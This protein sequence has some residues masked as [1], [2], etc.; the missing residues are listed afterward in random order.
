[1]YQL[2]GLSRGCRGT[3]WE[4]GANP[5][6]MG[7]DTACH[8]VL[9]DPLASRRHCRLLVEDG[10][11]HL[12]DLG[13]RNAALVNGVPSGEGE[14]QA[15]DEL[16]IGR[17]RFLLTK[18]APSPVVVASDAPQETLTL[19]EGM[20][21]TL[22]VT[23]ACPSSDL[24]PSTVQD[25]ALLHD[26]AR[27]LGAAQSMTEVV[28]ILHAL[29]GERLK[30][31]ACAFALVNAEEDLVFLGGEGEQ[32][33]PDEPLMTAI[34]T[35]LESSQGVLVP[36]RGRTGAAR[37]LR[38]CL[39][40]PATLGGHALAILAAET[41]IPHGAFDE[42]DLRFIM[43]LAQ[44]LAPLIRAVE[45]VEQ[46]RV[47]NA[48]LRDQGQD[49]PVLVGASGAMRAL[50][51]KI[52]AAGEY[53]GN[54][55]VTGETGTGKEL[56]A[57]LIHTHSP[58]RE[59]TFTLVNC[60]AIPGELF[61]SA[62]FGHERGAFT[63]A[64][65]ATSGLLSEADGGTLLLDEVGELSVENQARLLR[66][67]ETGTY[68]RVGSEEER[69]VDVR[70]VAATNR[71]IDEAIE[72]GVFRRDL[73]H[74]LNGMEILVPPLRDHSADVPAIA[75]HFFDAFHLDA[76][77][78]LEG[79][80]EEALADLRRRPWPGNLRELRNCVGR[81]VSFARGPLLERSDFTASGDNGGGDSKAMLTLKEAECAHIA[82][83]IEQCDGNV[84]AAAKAL[85]VGRS[86]LYRKLGE[87]GLQD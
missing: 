74:R 25:L 50:R 40:A 61:A 35:C 22:D 46:L 13:S 12:E 60:A 43:L 58:R 23:A 71:D 45:R 30:T 33:A 65:R 59:R 41:G 6:V 53:R 87:H 34:R 70:I 11:V 8:V 9:S 73:Y 32:A 77:R 36:T 68:R 86:T 44:S 66:V 5:I 75:R 2:V 24:R 31:K 38:F 62:V 1:M 84:P 19:S 56:V 76:K 83:S 29:C 51:A 82:R 15:G 39:A 57:R 42:D 7:R 52:A 78:P 54:V 47:E 16:A 10:R 48:R 26:A 21:T 20:P 18:A 17:E 63:G 79:I 14:L 55:F 67:I 3:T 4:V 28:Q 27:R 64:E 81:A 69:R 80:S 37:G 72:S 85:G 49:S